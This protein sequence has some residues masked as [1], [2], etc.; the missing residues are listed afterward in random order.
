MCG[1][2]RRSAAV[3]RVGEE[4]DRR[5]PKISRLVIGEGQELTPM[6]QAGVAKMESGRYVEAK[7]HFMQALHLAEKTTPLSEFS[8]S[9]SEASISAAKDGVEVQGPHDTKNSTTKGSTFTMRP[10][11]SRR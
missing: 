7:R 8:K 6:V 9:P 1:P 4:E 2:K 3:N 5:A 10:C 11:L